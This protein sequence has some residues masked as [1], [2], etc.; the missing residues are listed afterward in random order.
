MLRLV[1]LL[2]FISTMACSGEHRFE[3]SDAGSP[4][5]AGAYDDSGDGASSSGGTAGGKTCED[6]GKGYG[7]E[8]CCN[9][10]YCNGY[11]TQSGA[12]CHCL[13]SYGCAPNAICCPH[14]GCTSVE[15]CKE[16][17][18]WYENWKADGGGL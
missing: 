12:E 10:K 14:L 1:V 11:C 5:D 3:E 17:E 13:Y 4:D 18:E 2:V 16:F 15:T 7:V 6:V 8:T 9:G